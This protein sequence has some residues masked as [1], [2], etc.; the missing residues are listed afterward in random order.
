MCSTV[1]CYLLVTMTYIQHRDDHDLPLIIRYVGV[2]G[3]KHIVPYTSYIILLK[4]LS[5]RK[6]SL[7][8][9]I[10]MV[11]PKYNFSSPHHFFSSSHHFFSSPH[12]VSLLRTTFS[13]LPTTFS[14]LRTM[15][16]LGHA[17]TSRLKL[18]GWVWSSD[19]GPSV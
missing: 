3:A 16:F 7:Y 5:Y 18:D 2:R 10:C 15:F 9:A 6:V 4:G 12:H 8:R 14:L 13:L 19:Q 1:V 11:A 17:I